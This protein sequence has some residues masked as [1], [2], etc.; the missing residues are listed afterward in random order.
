MHHHGGG[1]LMSTNY[2]NTPVSDHDTFRNA[3]HHLVSDTN[4]NQDLAKVLPPH[5]ARGSSQQ[6]K[7][8]ELF[9][10]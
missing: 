3:I 8:R 4:L 6:R 1:N 9:K 2:L 10:A 5:T 7:N